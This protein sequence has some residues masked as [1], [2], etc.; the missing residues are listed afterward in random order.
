[1]FDK[2]RG[3]FF[4]E[5]EPE[6]DV[7]EPVKSPS[8]PPQ[9]NTEQKHEKLTQAWFKENLP[10]LRDQ[11]IDN[12]TKENVRTYLVAQK[13]WVNTASN[14]STAFSNVVMENPWL[15]EEKYRPTSAFGTQMYDK[16]GASNRDALVRKLAKDVGVW[17]FFSSRCDACHV[18]APVL[19]DLQDRLG[20]KILAISSDGKGL[21]DFPKYLKDK[22][23][24]AKYNISAFPT[25]MLYKNN[26]LYPVGEGLLSADQFIDRMLYFAKEYGWVTEGEWNKAQPVDYDGQLPAEFLQTIT[27]DELNNPQLLANK[28]KN[29]LISQMNQRTAK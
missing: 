12:P 5:V 21:P 13:L 1:M 18:Q 24:A 8:P 10:K 26:Q 29:Q 25:M 22:G 6:T 9:Q 7:E 23:Q 16:R 15:S 28:I 17:F 19:R 2:Y 3:F 27:I 14:F 20:M 11:A 4:H